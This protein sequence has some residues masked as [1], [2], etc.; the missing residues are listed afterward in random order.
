MRAAST[1]AYSGTTSSA[2]SDEASPPATLRSA[3]R[4]V[5]SSGGAEASAAAR[6]ASRP[7]ERGQS[8]T[9]LAYHRAGPRAACYNCF[10]GRADDARWL[11]LMHQ[12]PPRPNYLRVKIWRRLQRLGAVALKNSVY[13][14]P[15][16][17][18]AREDLGWVLR[19]IVDGEGAP[20]LVQARVRDGH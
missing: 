11:L 10:M 1:S 20:A 3:A 13:A 16:R 5:G 7:G 12:I 4:S 2:R 15:T 6:H 18:A 9:P 19:E 14:L 17:D 8:D